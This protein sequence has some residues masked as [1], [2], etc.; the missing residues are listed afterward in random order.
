MMNNF[1][2]LKMRLSLRF[3]T[4]KVRYRILLIRLKR[5]FLPL[6]K[7]INDIDAAGLQ[8]ALMLSA[9]ASLIVVILSLVPAPFETP[10]EEIPFYGDFAWQTDTPVRL[11]S[12]DFLET[13]SSRLFST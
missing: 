13:G 5:L 8:R 4:L 10:R 3:M 1:H 11:S 12:G 7:R 9:F 2:E 6:H